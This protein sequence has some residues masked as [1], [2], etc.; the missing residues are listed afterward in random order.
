MSRENRTIPQIT[1]YGDLSVML[2][3]E[4]VMLPPN[5]NLDSKHYLSL[6]GELPPQVN[7][8]STNL[9]VSLKS[10]MAQ[11]GL[12]IVESRFV[13][14][15]VFALLANC[16]PYWLNVVAGNDRF[17]LGALY[18][19]SEGSPSKT[20]V[21]QYIDQLKAQN[22]S[23]PQ[24]SLQHIQIGLNNYVWVETPTL[25]G[26]IVGQSQQNAKTVNKLPRGS[27][28]ANI[29][30]FLERDI[31]Y[32]KGSRKKPGPIVGGDIPYTTTQTEFP[33]IPVQGMGM[34]IHGLAVLNKHDDLAS[35]LVHGASQLVAQPDNTCLN[36][37]SPHPIIAEFF[38]TPKKIINM[39]KR[40]LRVGFIAK[41][42]DLTVAASRKL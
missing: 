18:S 31:I 4:T 7:A 16:G 32:Q 34:I 42:V 8:S 2:S 36:G 41:P 13:Q 5:S 1:V 33:I 23:L 9:R 6:V 35:L 30:K 22:P 10:A 19:L 37:R 28:R 15:S 3:A 11:A 38:D 27:D 14:D 39:L 25:I 40:G 29:G 20:D 21:H 24:N 12:E 17:D 26:P